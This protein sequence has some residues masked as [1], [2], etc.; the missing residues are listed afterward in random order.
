VRV[1]VQRA[2]LGN[3]RPL[4]S[5][6]KFP[7]DEGLVARNQTGACL[8]FSREVARE[9]THPPVTLKGTLENELFPSC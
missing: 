3:R 5:R 8:G 4:S 6:V 9:V 7:D 2:L 1:A